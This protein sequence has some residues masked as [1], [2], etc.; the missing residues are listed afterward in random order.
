[1]AHLGC[2]ALLGRANHSRLIL[3][4]R[5]VE[6]RLEARASGAPDGDQDDQAAKDPKA[7]GG[8]STH[9]SGI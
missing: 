5:G 2:C 7:Q 3:A 1:M 9:R 8:L 4:E 6:Q